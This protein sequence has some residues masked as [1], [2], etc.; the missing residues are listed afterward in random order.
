[1]GAEV[2]YFSVCREEQDEFEVTFVEKEPYDEFR[3]NILDDYEFEETELGDYY[4]QQIIMTVFEK[5]L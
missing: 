4:M 3:D 5:T 1:M 2:T